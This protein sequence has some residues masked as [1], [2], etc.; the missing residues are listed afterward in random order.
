MKH[1]LLL[2][3][4]FSAAFASAQS[5]WVRNRAGYYAQFGYGVIP[6][7]ENVFGEDENTTQGK[8][9]L[10]EQTFQLYT[11]YGMTRKTTALFSLPIRSI[12]GEFSNDRVQS[13]QQHV[14]LSNIMLGLRRTVISGRMPLTATLKVELPAVG[15]S[16]DDLTMPHGFDALTALPMLSTGMGFNRGY[17]F[18]YGGYGLRTNDYSDFVNGG[19]EA[20]VKA[21]DWWF[22]AFTDVH[23]PL[24]N[25]NA[26]MSTAQTVTRLYHDNQGWWAYGL[27]IAHEFNRF[28]GFNLY[29]SSAGWGQYVPKKPA[30]GAAIYFRWD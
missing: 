12:Q 20:G 28:I 23:Y 6:S 18:A 7:Y 3:A 19:L 2:L 5:P 11:E 24:E 8:R 9:S 1:L 4:L 10:T 21:T 17:W 27:K 15:L 16:D 13:K 30:L 14:G 26:V 22:M 29:A 25:G